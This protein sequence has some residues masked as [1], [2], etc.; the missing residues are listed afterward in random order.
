M[1]KGATEAEVAAEIERIRRVMTADPEL[2][3]TQLGE[4]LGMSH[5]TARK[6]LRRLGLYVP[7]GIARERTVRWERKVGA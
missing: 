2:T 5:V 7:R 1:K 6:Y 4:R 3:P